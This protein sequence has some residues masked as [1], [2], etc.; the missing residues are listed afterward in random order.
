M[1]YIYKFI[2]YYP[3][4]MILQYHPKWLPFRNLRRKKKNCPSYKQQ[5]VEHDNSS[6]STLV[7][8]I[9]ILT[10]QANRVEHVET[11]AWGMPISAT[12]SG[13]SVKPW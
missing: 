5:D 4:E 3:Q 7:E 1:H 12:T 10:S 6:G 11:G 13:S 8:H 9:L 2:Q